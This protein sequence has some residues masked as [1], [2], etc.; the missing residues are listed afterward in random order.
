MS[1]PSSILVIAAHPDDEILGCGGTIARHRKQGDRVMVLIL[2]DGVGGRSASAGT[3]SPKE[4]AARRD[5]AQ[6][7][8]RVLGVED[9]ELL[10]YPDNRMDAAPLLDIV[11]DIEKTLALCKPAVVYTHHGSDVNIDHRRV[12]DAVIAACRPQPG[13]P[14]KQLLFFE[15]PSS[16]EWRPPSSLPPFEPQWFVDISDSLA[17]KLEALAVYEAELR[18]FPHPRSLAAVEHLARWRGATVGLHAAEAFVLGRSIH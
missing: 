6:R 15:T 7:A 14:V 16:T 2:A 10:S 18:E 11:Q 13:H 1:R 9:L 8:N 4:V 17:L 5:C 12:Q 3:V